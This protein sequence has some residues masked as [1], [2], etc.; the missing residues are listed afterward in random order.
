MN[1]T[2]QADPQGE[3]R[4]SQQVA[5]AFASLFVYWA[6][7]DRE[8]REA[9]RPGWIPDEVLKGAGVKRPGVKDG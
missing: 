7:R 8:E 4:L 3:C 2:P 1:T 6:R 5:D 9:G